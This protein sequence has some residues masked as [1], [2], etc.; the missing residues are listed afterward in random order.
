LSAKS[1]ENPFGA[2]GRPNRNSVTMF[3]A[4][5]NEGARCRF[6]FVHDFNERPTTI[7]VD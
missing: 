6:D 3:K 4:L 1:S 7:V 5:R 2:I